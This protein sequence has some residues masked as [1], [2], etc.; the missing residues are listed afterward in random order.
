MHLR[1]H[2]P[3]TERSRR[4]ARAPIAAALLAAAAVHAAPAAAQIMSNPAQWYIDNQIYSSRVFN[5]TVANSMIASGTSAG[6]AGAA[7]ANEAAPVRDYT[8]FVA[9]PGNL[10][11]A[12][13]AA[14]EGGSPAARRAAQ[15]R[16]DGYVD[17]Y[18]RT[19]AK[20]RFPADD[21]AYAYEYYVVNNWNILKDLV[22]VPLEQD[23]RLRGARDGFERIEF[24]ARKRQEQVS[25]LQERAIYEQ[26]RAQLGSAAAVRKMTDAQKQEAAET[27]AISLGVNWSSYLAGLERGDDALA[28]QAR[29]A[30]RVGLEK[31]FGRPIDRISIDERGVVVR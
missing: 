19:A 11:P 21:L 4:A 3:D 10:V 20:D 26:F 24:A 16:Y 31:L 27:L 1:G 9:T 6:K 5:G 2:G 30:A 12:A 23:P 7:P 18:V 22:D 29:D 25:P 8:R 17:M 13:L 14:R 28:Q 15:E